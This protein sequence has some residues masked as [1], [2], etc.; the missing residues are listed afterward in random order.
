MTDSGRVVIAGAGT[1]KTYTLVQAYIECLKKHRPYEILAITFTQKAAAEM[2]ARVISKV[3]ELGISPRGLLSAP[4]CTFHALC[5]QI[6]GDDIGEFELLSPIDDEKLCFTIAEQVILSKLESGRSDIGRLIA[7]FQIRGFG[8]SKGLADTLVSLLPDIREQGLEPMDCGLAGI[9]GDIDIKSCLG[10]IRQNYEAFWNSK[11]S[12]GAREKLVGFLSDLDVFT[13]IDMSSEPAFSVAF[14]D[15]RARL[16][17]RFGDT[18]L[19]GALIDSVLKLGAALCGQYTRPDAEAI[20]GLLADYAERM[21]EHKMA[22][23]VFGFG[24]LLVLSKRILTRTDSKFKFV[25]VDEYQDTSPIQ[26]QLVRLLTRQAELFIVGDP[27]QSIYGFRGADASVFDRVSG[28]RESLTLSR[29]SGGAVIELVNLLAKATLPDFGDEDMLESMHEYHGEA[30]AI[31]G[32]KWA[33]DVQRLIASGSYQPS[34][35]VVLVRRIKTAWPMAAELHALDIPAR[36]YGGEGFYS[37]QE[38]CDFAAALYFLIEPTAPLPKLILMRSPFCQ[39]P[40]SALVDWEH[41]TMPPIFDEL[42]GLLGTLR[43]AEIIDRLL[44]DGGYAVAMPAS[45]LPNILKLRTLLIDVLE[46][47]DVKIRDLWSKLDRPPKEGLAEAFGSSEQAVQIMTLHQSKGL[48]FPVVILADLAS[49][50]PS[51]SDA[52]VF[53]PTVGLAVTHK[54]R[55]LA[56]CAPQTSDEKKK[57]P[58]PIDLVR[59][60]KRQKADAELPR[61]LYVG[62]TRAKH[63]VY[64]VDLEEADRG[65]S[66]MRLV[67]QGRESS[68][69]TFE[70]LMPVRRPERS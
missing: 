8:D 29:R 4:I 62:V 57:Y 20:R 34:D 11:L 7:R 26:E 40:D 36:V 23:R 51:D 25:L 39:L 31:W 5:A 27:K 49:T 67:K 54:N 32:A 45:Q 16:A 38:I 22:N 42:R 52:I 13:A 15:M 14:R 10:E 58:A 21:D 56:L 41:Q 30:G 70:K 19:R 17:G 60:R 47:Y 44:I 61:L 64:I 66:L 6:V 55:P 63:A 9:A 12:D 18:A 48:E 69:T 1:G 2:R 46:N 37:R 43:V 28:T 3:Q 53:D 35:I 50:P 68:Q 24:D 59:Q 65:L 33:E